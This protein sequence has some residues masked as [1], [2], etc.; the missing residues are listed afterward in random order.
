MWDHKGQYQYQQLNLKNKM[1]SCVDKLSPYLSDICT[2]SQKNRKMRGLR[3]QGK[4][5]NRKIEILIPSCTKF[6]EFSYKNNHKPCSNQ[7]KI[8]P[9]NLREHR[10]ILPY[11][12][13]EKTSFKIFSL[14]INQTFNQSSQ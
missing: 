14:S 7:F 3:T 2:G 13:T 8:T 4:Y 12:L 5:G 6:C 1:T 10:Q 9:K 11:D